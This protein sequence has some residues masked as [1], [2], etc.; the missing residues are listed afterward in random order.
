MTPA[1]SGRPLT[2]RR[3]LTDANIRPQLLGRG[4]KWGREADMEP[5]GIDDCQYK[6]HERWYIK[7]PPTKVATGMTC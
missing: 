2:F 6:S 4:S 7:R 3:A 1:L 5:L